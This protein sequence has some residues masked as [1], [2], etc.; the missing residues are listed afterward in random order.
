[1]FYSLDLGGST[2]D[3][4]RF[5]RNG[6]SVIKSLESKE[7]DKSS[8]KEIFRKANVD[9]S[10]AEKIILTGGHSRTFGSE[11]EGVPLNIV[12]E[13]DAIG[14][15]GVFLAK[16]NS[17]LVCSMGTGTCFVSARKGIFKH[18]GGTGVGG[19]TFLGLS[20]TLLQTDTFSDLQQLVKNGESHSVDL[21]VAEIVGGGIG[22]VPSSA[23]AANFA[24]ASQQNSK[25]DIARGIANM[26]GQTIASLAVFAARTENHKK[27]ILGGKLIRLPQ[28]VEIAK[29]TADI[30]GR[31]IIV[32]EHA[33]YMSAIGAGR[34]HYKL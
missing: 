20:R 31:K 8:L 6:F 29:K 12:S 32:P 18:V 27:I 23:T 5:D 11:F 19:G 10:L 25:N 3:I 9:Y 28:I 33:E 2:V 30:Y 21:L 34:I 15:G 7:I 24:K 4:L 22:F 1:M 26:V 14:T 16:T 17:G 13:I